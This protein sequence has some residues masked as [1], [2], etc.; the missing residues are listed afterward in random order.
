MGKLEGKIA[1]ITDGR[2]K[3]TR[4]VRLDPTDYAARLYLGTVLLQEDGDPAGAVAQYQ[5]FLADGP[6]PAIV[7]E[8]AAELRQAYQ[9]AGVPVPAA[10]G[11]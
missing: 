4:A 5:E 2:S 3:L 1:L 6:P 7:K 11:D 10:V 9:K 8:A